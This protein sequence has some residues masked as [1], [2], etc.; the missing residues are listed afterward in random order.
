[1]TWKQT[2]IQ[3]CQAYI[4]E[5]GKTILNCVLDLAVGVLKNETV[6]PYHKN[7]LGSMGGM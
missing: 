3:F 6:N 7:M 1:M 2:I 4:I 5:K